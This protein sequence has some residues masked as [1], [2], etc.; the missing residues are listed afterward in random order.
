[1]FLICCG[2]IT[3]ISVG[4]TSLAVEDKTSQPRKAEFLSQ[5][6]LVEKSTMEGAIASTVS[7]VVRSERGSDAAS[8]SVGDMQQNNVS[9]RELI[10]QALTGSQYAMEQL[11]LQS[12]PRSYPSL[13]KALGGWNSEEQ[14]AAA[15]TLTL[16]GNIEVIDLLITELNSL[17]STRQE[18]AAEVLGEIGDQRAV[19]ALIKALSDK[20]THG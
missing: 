18:R 7:S 5:E 4:E 8:P 12:N 13:V 16:L 1:M 10:L 3:V 2:F 6:G 14:E 11:V 9:L 19:K 17:N 20:D 15:E